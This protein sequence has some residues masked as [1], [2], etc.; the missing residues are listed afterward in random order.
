MMNYESMYES[1]PQKHNQ[2]FPP[3]KLS[4][5]QRRLQ[6]PSTVHQSQGVQHVVGVDLLLNM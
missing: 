6:S 3:K 2:C 1:S 5:G 4:Q